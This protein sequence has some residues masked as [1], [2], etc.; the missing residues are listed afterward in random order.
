MGLNKSTGNM[1]DW[2]THTWNTVKGQCPHGCRY[3][4]MKRWGKQK[5]ARLDETEF[6]TNLGEGST[7]FVG[8]S[9]D[10]F[11]EGIPFEWISKTLKHCAKFDNTYL[12][13]SKN[14]E[15]ID[16]FMYSLPKS[17]I[18]GTT[19]ETNLPNKYM[20]ATPSPASRCFSMS[21]LS[22]HGFNTVVTIEPIMRFNLNPMVELVR[23]CSPKWVNIGANTDNKT[24][25]PEPSQYDIVSLI[26]EL[27]KFTEVKIKSNLG[28][29]M[30]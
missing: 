10:L 17:V 24:K 27:T 5:P 21:N 6:K 18:V 9:C 4:Y 3:C 1:F 12:L 2:V 7:I 13:Q 23:K 22:A 19:I 25:L 26:N 14:P 28:R 16:Q 15:R 30:K 29:L 8:S 11:A 20:G